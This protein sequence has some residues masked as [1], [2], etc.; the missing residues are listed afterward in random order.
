MLK[1]SGDGRAAALDLRLVNLPAEMADMPRDEPAK[2]AAAAFEIHQR[3]MANRD[4]TYLD[5]SG[6]PSPIK[7][8]LQLVFCDLGT[9][10]PG[11]NAYRE[12]RDQLAALGDARRTWSGSCTT[13]RTTATRR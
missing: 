4:R 9:P 13:P 3:W 12:L 10:R 11:W 8:A 5:A 7:G 1:V 6:Q 2:I